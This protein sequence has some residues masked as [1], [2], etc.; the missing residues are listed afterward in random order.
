MPSKKKPKT[1]APKPRKAGRPPTVD[2]KAID[3]ATRLLSKTG[4][5]AKQTADYLLSVGAR[6]YLSLNTYAEKE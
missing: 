6:R 5:T 2:Q 1:S 3:K 4:Q